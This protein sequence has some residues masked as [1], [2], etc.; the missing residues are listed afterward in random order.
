M[1]LIPQLYNNNSKRLYNRG[2][3][4]FIILCLVL[5]GFKYLIFDIVIPKT[6]SLTVPAKWR[7]L[8]LRQS[9]TI[10]HGYLGA[11]VSSRNPKDSSYEE[12]IAGSKGKQY[13][14][15]VDYADT[16]A[17]GYSIHYQ[18][19]NWLVKRDYLIDSFSIK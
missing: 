14:L 3:F 16:I 12:W 17:T 10:V 18:Y 1:P 5:T 2:T 8:P 11:P 7:M 19:S 4:V 15:T 13:Y 6:A 9:K